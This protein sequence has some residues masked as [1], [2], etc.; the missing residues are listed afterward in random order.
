MYAYIFFYFA[1]LTL[2]LSLVNTNI[3]SKQILNL[4]SVSSSALLSYNP[5]LVNLHDA[6]TIITAYN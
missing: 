1:F 6:L 3:L 2:S 4:L 5:C